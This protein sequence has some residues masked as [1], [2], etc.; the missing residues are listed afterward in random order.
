MTELPQYSRPTA[1]ED[2]PPTAFLGEGDHDG[3]VLTANFNMPPTTEFSDA[4]EARAARILADRTVVGSQANSFESDPAENL[5]GSTTD[6]NEVRT[7][8]IPS[9]SPT[10][11][12]R[13]TSELYTQVKRII[14]RRTRLPDSASALVAFWAVSTWFQDVF[15][16]LPCLLITGPAHEAMVILRVLHELCCAPILL[17]GFKR[18]DLKDLG[19][20]RTLLI[21]EQNLDARTAAL[22]GN[23]TNRDFALVE[24]GSNMKSEFS[25]E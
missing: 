15:T 3:S 23:L 7:P 25:R 10:K 13:E 18:A 19:R 24:Q 12:D 4:L 22:L 14:A 17:A 9:T 2:M 16:V 5:S 1:E 21:S 8:G 11:P 6:A 20:Y